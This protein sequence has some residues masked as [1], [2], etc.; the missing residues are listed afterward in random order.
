[1]AKMAKRKF[2]KV[3]KK[4]KRVT[5]ASFVSLTRMTIVF[6]IPFS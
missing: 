6:L 2:I 1:M 3:Q 5:Q 4:I